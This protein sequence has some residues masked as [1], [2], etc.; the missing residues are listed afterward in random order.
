[1]YQIYKL[2]VCLCV[3][4]CISVWVCVYVLCSS[5]NLAKRGCA[6]GSGS[7]RLGSAADCDR[8]QTERPVWQS[9]GSVFAGSR[10]VSLTFFCLT[11]RSVQT[12]TDRTTD[13]HSP[14]M[15]GFYSRD[16]F[17]YQ[18]LSICEFSLWFSFSLLISLSFT[19]DYICC[20]FFLSLRTWTACVC[21]RCWACLLSIPQ[22]SCCSDRFN[23]SASCCPTPETASLPQ[24]WTNW[25]LPSWP[26]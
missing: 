1:M 8:T 5:E 2:C 3:C 11:T 6:F 14:H 4:V 13:S 24:C 19:R 12:D 25:V 15:Y 21:C 23:A 22:C 18:S 9:G 17:M 7:G 16:T 20:I 10:A 26:T